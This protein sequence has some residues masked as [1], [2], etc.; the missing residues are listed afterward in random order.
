M[1]IIFQFIIA[2]AGY[3]IIIQ[4]IVKGFNEGLREPIDKK[5]ICTTI[6]KDNTPG[7][8][9]NIFTQKYENMIQDAKSALKNMGFSKE[10]IER[11]I[12]AALKENPTSTE[13]LLKT[14]LRKTTI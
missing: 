5:Y 4:W 14:S 13:E 7:D 6:Q 11:S 9:S 12:E 8:D 10:I 3:F 1:H 2:A